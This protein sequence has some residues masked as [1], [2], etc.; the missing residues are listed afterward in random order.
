MLKAGPAKRLV[1]YVNESARWHGH[2]TYHALLELFRERGLAGATV[3]RGMAGYTGHGAID[4][5]DHLEF[6]SGLP[7]KV[8]VTDTPEA[9]ESVLPDVCTMVEHGLVEVQDTTV[10]KFVSGGKRK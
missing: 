7:V 6:V 3:V 4:T 5:I 8:E 1:V 9:I 2:S 10:V